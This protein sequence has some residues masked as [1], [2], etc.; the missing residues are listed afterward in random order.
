M[1][2]M[3][4]IKCPFHGIE[5]LGHFP[6]GIELDRMDEM[7][8]AT[9]GNLKENFQEMKWECDVLERKTGGAS[10]LIVDKMALGLDHIHPALIRG[11]LEQTRW[12]Q[13]W[14]LGLDLAL[15]AWAEWLYHMLCSITTKHQNNSVLPGF[16]TWHFLCTFE[17]IGPIQYIG[18]LSFSQT[19][20][21][22]YS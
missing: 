12:E 14:M 2:R 4:G 5:S 18:L 15:T 20:Q 8:C 17:Y 22:Y 19:N 7:D 16:E 1:D 11:A 13:V 21:L 9:E 3:E 10:M 6:S